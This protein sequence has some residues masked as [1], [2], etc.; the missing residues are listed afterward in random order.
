[1]CSATH[2]VSTKLPC[3]WFEVQELP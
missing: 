2:L 1:M 3:V